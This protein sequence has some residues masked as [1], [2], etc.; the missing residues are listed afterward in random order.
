MNAVNSAVSWEATLR[1]LGLNPAED[2]ALGGLSVELDSTR[3]KRRR[4][5][6]KHKCANFHAVSFFSSF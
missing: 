6:K 1:R 5:M 4:K 3:R 2:A